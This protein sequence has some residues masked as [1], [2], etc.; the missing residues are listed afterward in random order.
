MKVATF[1]QLRLLKALVID[2]LSAEVLG[3]DS[4]LAASIDLKNIGSLTAVVP[5]L[6]PPTPESL[7][8]LLTSSSDKVQALNS[9]F[10]LITSIKPNQVHIHVV[11]FI[12]PFHSQVSL[13]ASGFGLR[14]ARKVSTRWSLEAD[15]VRPNQLPDLAFVLMAKASQLRKVSQESLYF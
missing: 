3:Q 13:L 12:L 1:R 8:L 4:A 11:L 10:Q 9:A 14:S 2:L 7:S 6:P 5:T 15:F